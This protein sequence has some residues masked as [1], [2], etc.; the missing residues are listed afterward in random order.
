[1]RDTLTEESMLK[2]VRHMRQDLRERMLTAGNLTAD[3]VEAGAFLAHL[4]QTLRL[5]LNHLH[6]AKHQ[7]DWSRR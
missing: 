4:E 5:I 6:A 1:M 2:L 3:Y 7:P